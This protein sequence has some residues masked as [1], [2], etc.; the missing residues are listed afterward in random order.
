MLFRSSA[1][2]I[3]RPITMYYYGS[4]SNILNPSA[5][6]NITTGGILATS[7]YC[8]C[9]VSASNFYASN[10]Y[11]DATQLTSRSDRRLK[12]DIVPLSNAV[13]I[14]AGL[15]GVY[16]VLKEDPEKRKIGFIAQDVETVLP[17]LVF[18]GTHKS[19]KYESINI[20]LLEAIKELNRECDSFLS[21]L[22]A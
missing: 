11:A 8:T 2:W 21:T 6:L 15:T 7:I 4:S 13:D 16:Y 14:I 18:T 20:V 1:N 10:Y 12:K 9:N 22:S 17:D 3:Q 19:L 5:A